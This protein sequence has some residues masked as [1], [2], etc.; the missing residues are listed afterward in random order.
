MQGP[1]SGHGASN[2]ANAQSHYKAKQH[3]G[4]GCGTTDVEDNIFKAGHGVTHGKKY[5]AKIIYDQT[6][7]K[8]SADTGSKTLSGSLN[9]NVRVI[10]NGS[11]SWNVVL[12]F[13]G[14]YLECFNS[15]AQHDNS[16]PCCYGPSIGWVY[17]DLNWEICS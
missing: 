15:Q 11:E 12:S 9:S 7:G 13:D 1:A 4:N 16:Q 5:S 8:L 6:I 17:E 10:A 3:S 2:Q 14:G